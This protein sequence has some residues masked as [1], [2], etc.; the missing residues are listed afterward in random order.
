[1]A[2]A[3]PSIVTGDQFLTRI[4]TNI[5]CQTQLIGTLGWQELAQPGGLA[6]TMMA[7]L[8]TL[9]VALFGIRLLFGPTPGGRDVVLEILKV[10]IVLALAFSWPAFRT[11]IHDVVVAGPGEIAARIAA[12]VPDGESTSFLAQ[13]QAADDAIL[14]LTEAGTGRQV[15]AFIDREA[16]GGTFR[17]TA[18]RDEA[19]FGNARLIW[20][21]GLI[22]AFALL[23]LV[24]GL[25]LA[26][27]PLAAGLLLFEATRGLFT[28]WLRGLVL[29]LI[30]LV[31]VTVVLA[32]QLGVLL[33]WLSDAL[34]VRNLGYATPAAPTEL[35][36]MTLAFTIVQFA[37][38]AIL[39]KVAFTRG[40]VSLPTPNF[41]R[42][43]EARQVGPAIASEPRGVFAESRAQRIS[44][45][46]EMQLRREN[47]LDARST[48]IRSLT[49][50]SADEG[51]AGQQ[52]TTIAGA[53]E[54]LGS[55]WR[56]THARSSVASRRRDGPR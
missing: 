34:R 24:A 22:G 40:W 30:G 44:N 12:P 2:T 56:R 37:M 17:G 36:A 54:R 45:V 4:I 38:I 27:A 10:G 55:S 21:A 29:A 18:L 11:V 50:R 51:G 6:S 13:L 41:E 39:A 5:E 52:S 43:R 31:G 26:L 33:P 9:F 15:G 14:R 28:G 3:C 16:A 46:M 48:Q 35:F 25:L 19:G 20:L 23:R 53:R 8:L 32:V 1:M 42:Q 7:G 47:S 49:T